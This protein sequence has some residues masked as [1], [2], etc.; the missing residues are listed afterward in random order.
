LPEVPD[1]ETYR[2]YL[3]AH[4]L[5]QRI[6]HVKVPSSRQLAGISPRGL[7]RALV[8]RRFESTRRH[9]KHLFARIG[10]G[11]WLMLHFGMT[12]SLSY[13]RNSGGKPPYTRLLIDF[14]RNRRLAFVDP[15][16]LGRIALAGR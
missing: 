1:V 11:R 5:H 7:G 4:A 10:K 16:K 15:R 12:G 13:R 3:A 2:R 6:A 14:G 9:G 8:R